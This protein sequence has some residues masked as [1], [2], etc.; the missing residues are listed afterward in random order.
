MEALKR[1]LSYETYESWRLKLEY[2]FNLL[3]EINCSEIDVL[4]VINS[5]DKNKKKAFA[6]FSFDQLIQCDYKMDDLNFLYRLKY[7]PYEIQGEN[8]VNPNEGS[9][10]IAYDSNYYNNLNR[11]DRLE[12][13]NRN[14]GN[15]EFNSYYSRLIKE[16]LFVFTNFKG[17]FTTQQW[18]DILEKKFTDGFIYYFSNYILSKTSKLLDFKSLHIAHLVVE[19]IYG[20]NVLFNE[21]NENAIFSDDFKIEL[22]HFYLDYISEKNPTHFN[23]MLDLYFYLSRKQIMSN[24]NINLINNFQSKVIDE[25]LEYI[26]EDIYRKAVLERLEADP[27]T[28]NFYR[29]DLFVRINNMESKDIF[30][31]LIIKDYLQILRSEKFYS[32][33]YDLKGV[34]NLLNAIDNARTKETY[35]DKLFID[36]INCFASM[37]SHTHNIDWNKY[38]LTSRKLRFHLGILCLVIKDHGWDTS[39]VE[40]ILDTYKQIKVINFE[41]HNPLSWEEMVQDTFRIPGNDILKNDEI[42]TYYIAEL[43]KDMDSVY[44]KDYIKAIESNL[45][46]FEIV[47]L[48]K[49]LKGIIDIENEPPINIENLSI[50]MALSNAYFLLN[51]GCPVE[52]LMYINYAE[53]ISIDKRIITHDSDYLNL[54]KYYCYINTKEFKK[55]IEFAT[56]IQDKSKSIP[57]VATANYFKKNYNISKQLFESY[58]KDNEPDIEAI[59]NYS[60]VLISMDMSK[61]AI[62]WCEK[63]IDQYK[64]DYLLNANLA[65]AYN[66]I[67]NVKALYYYNE[68]KRQNPK[69]KPAIYGTV[70]NI[71]NIIKEV[72]TVLDSLEEF[73]RKGSL[74]KAFTVNSQNAIKLLSKLN[75]PDDEIRIL[76]DINKA[77]QLASEKPINIEKLNENELSDMLK[78]Y[79]KMSLDHYG[80]EVTRE[81]PQG[82]ATSNPGELD[83]FI[84]KSGEDYVNIAT[85]E[86]K[87]WSQ[88]KFKKQLGQLF[89]Y[90]REYGGFGFTIIFNKEVKLENVLRDRETILEN[91]CFEDEKGNKIFEKANLMVDMGCYDSALESILLTS[92]RNPELDDSVVRVYHFVLNVS[93]QERKDLARIVRKK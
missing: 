11:F 38:F 89:G 76:K 2:Y 90:L 70:E 17:I 71:N 3:M 80:Y 33:Y 50:G 1:K 53:R 85:G 75:I 79:L 37:A 69:Y 83:F 87:I 34:E 67:D 92:H 39:L 4:S 30:T 74:A 5:M 86:N 73:D 35:Q 18:E 57:R 14:F 55:A 43:L 10:L 68:A 58:F 62:K 84:F 28:D 65:C 82:Y 42:L 78:D 61:E 56:Q 77:I 51:N 25:L 29:Y 49:S 54:L 22:L 27:L 26:N 6:D 44:V 47:L 60:A 52:S 24:N 21:R 12:Q 45:N 19:K 40:Y 88:D 15:F 41:G 63:Y 81:S 7:V 9:R 36:F 20:I 72:P 66:N 91:L 59:V 64:D 8:I 48:N 13:I 16:V 93:R 32:H 31:D 23:L 46:Y